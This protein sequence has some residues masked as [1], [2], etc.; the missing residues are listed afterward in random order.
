M[1]IKTLPI[2]AHEKKADTI[3]NFLLLSVKYAITEIAK[4]GG[5]SLFQS[6]GI[7]TCPPVCDHQLDWLAATAIIVLQSDHQL[8][9]GGSWLTHSLYWQNIQRWP[10]YADMQR[11]YFICEPTTNHHIDNTWV[12]YFQ[13]TRFCHCSHGTLT[14]SCFVIS[15]IRTILQKSYLI[16]HHMC[17]RWQQTMQVRHVT[18]TTH[19][20]SLM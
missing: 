11:R 1:R 7:L 2:S 17:I 13:H 19:I 15:S 18:S 14:V 16:C 8:E 4:K 9:F 6:G 5:L 10:P 3:Y 20:P 12:H